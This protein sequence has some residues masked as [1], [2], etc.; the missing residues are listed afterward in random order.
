MT[1][2]DKC[3]QAAREVAHA[4]FDD[5]A[6]EDEET[7]RIADAIE[8]VAIA[9]GEEKYHEGYGDAIVDEAESRELEE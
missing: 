8:K 3:E 6:I 9:Y 5:S 7:P 4:I 1:L 2:R